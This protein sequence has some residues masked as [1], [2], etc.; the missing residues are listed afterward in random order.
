MQM[1]TKHPKFAQNVF[2]NAKMKKYL[3]AKTC[4][5]VIEAQNGKELPPC[6]AQKFANGLRKWAKSVGATHYAL[7]FDPFCGGT[8]GKLHSWISRTVNGNLK[9]P[10][11]KQLLTDECDASAFCCGNSPC[12][13]KGQIRWFA[14]LPAYVEDNCL[15]IPATLSC[16][17]AALDEKLPL[18]RSCLALDKCVTKL[19][20]LLGTKTAHVF[21][22]VGAEQEYFLLEKYLYLQRPDLV[23]TGKILIEPSFTQ[24]NMPSNYCQAPQKKVANFWQQTERRLHLLGIVAQTQHN[25]VAP[26]QAELAPCCA[27]AIAAYWQNQRIMQT[28]RIVADK[29]NLACLLHEKPFSHLSGSGKHNNWSLFCNG[30]NLFD[31]GTTPQQH[32]QYAVLIACMVQ[33]VSLHQELLCL[34]AASCG[35]D[36]RL[37]QCEA[38]PPVISLSLG[39]ALADL[40]EAASPNFRFGHQLLSPPKDAPRNRTSPLVLTQGKF[41]FRLVGACA[42]IAACNTV[43]NAAFAETADELA[44]Q[45]QKSS[46]VWTQ[47]HAFVA[48]VLKNCCNVLFDGDN[49][50][51]FWQEE[52]K[53]RKLFWAENVPKTLAASKQSNLLQK[54]KILSAE[55]QNAWRTAMLNQYCQQRQNQAIV[56]AEMCRDVVPIVDKTLC[57]QRKAEEQTGQNVPNRHLSKL[58]CCK[59][60]LDLCARRLSK[61]I[62]NATRDVEQRAVLFAMPLEKIILVTKRWLS[63]ARNLCPQ[64]L[65]P[66]PD[67]TEILRYD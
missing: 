29:Q 27:P 21:S 39:N 1:S 25:E 61:Q 32:A 62:E 51:A 14:P 10:T 11:A 31:R 66:F 17:K 44:T 6:H 63:T 9:T 56:L 40:A 18:F 13:A 35:N 47:A 41:E 55:E 43:L 54:L 59:K 3:P 48:N 67:C 4:A 7:V 46:N 38:P 20:N 5:A 64:N 45:L 24:K 15:H 28:L 49:Y 19:V 23:Q 42:S 50:S 52:A 26:C 8:V 65:W 37:G 33:A 34:S 12:N 60:M 2:D 22:V 16:N 36:E 30:K 53:R 57:L 58:L